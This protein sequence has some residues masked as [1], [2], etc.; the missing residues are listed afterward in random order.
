MNSIRWTSVLAAGAAA[1][2]AS[3]VGTAH[4]A[5]ITWSTGAAFG[6]ANGH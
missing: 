1:L 2:F 3:V 6:G 5:D 4:A